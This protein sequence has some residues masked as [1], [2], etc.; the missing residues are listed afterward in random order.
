[1]RCAR[2]ALAATA[3]GTAAMLTGGGEDGSMAA[4]QA[5]AAGK[6]KKTTKLERRD[7]KYGK[8]LFAGN[9]RALY[10]FTSDAGRTSN[11]DGEC[12]AAWP[13]FYARGKLRGGPGVS[14]KLLGK[15]TR[16]DGRRQVTYNGHPLYFYVHDPR[17]QILC[18]N[19]FEFGGDWLVVR[20][21]GNPAP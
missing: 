13:P 1:M 9:G 3:V 19:V 16:S 2:V 7:S 10:L 14:R 8:V 20:A 11:C 15:T 18:H 12:A 5:S 6:A 21:S 4:T 17:G